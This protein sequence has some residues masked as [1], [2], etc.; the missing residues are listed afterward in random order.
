MASPEVKIFILGEIHAHAADFFSVF[1]AGARGI[2]GE[3]EEVDPA[4]FEKSDK[5]QRTGQQLAAQVECAIHIEEETADVIS[6]VN[7]PFVS[8][9]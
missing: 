1:A 2:V 6:C 9:V 7:Q 4:L 3:K 8:T 5:L